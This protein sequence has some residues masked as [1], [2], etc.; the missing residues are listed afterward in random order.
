[1]TCRRQVKA[2][3]NAHSGSIPS[4]NRRVPHP[5]RSLRR[6]GWSNL[7]L[8]TSTEAGLFLRLPPRT[9]LRDKPRS[10]KR[11][12]GH[13]L[14]VRSPS[15]SNLVRYSLRTIRSLRNRVIQSQLTSE[16]GT[17]T[18]TTHTALVAHIFR[19]TVRQI[20]FYLTRQRNQS[21]RA[22][23]ELV[24]RGRHNL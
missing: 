9:H 10:Q 14:K 22:C 7:A 24:E 2:R 15:E 17:K 20:V 4:T 12:L 8:Q 18:L 6:V 21:R 13:P 1:M 11:D 19:P 5:S 16:E 3:L 23:P